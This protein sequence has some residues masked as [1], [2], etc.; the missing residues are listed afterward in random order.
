MKYKP[1]EAVVKRETVVVEARG[2]APG[3]TEG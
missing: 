3:S 1:N 2:T